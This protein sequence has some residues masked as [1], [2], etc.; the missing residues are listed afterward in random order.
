ME[1]F[2]AERDFLADSGFEDRRR[3]ALAGLDLNKIDAPI[4]DIIESLFLLPYCYTLQSCYG[5]F[6]HPGQPDRYGV[7]ALD[8]Y[9]ADTIVEYRLAYVALCIRNNEDGLALR[10]ELRGLVSIDP[11]NV[12]FGS[13]DWFRHKHINSFALQV[14]P[15]RFQYRD[16][17][18]VGIDE[19]L[20]LERTRNNVFERLST[21]VH[22]RRN[23]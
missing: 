14:E 10:A 17:A 9:T 2:A 16:T 7:E 6:V 1:T 22:E 11:Q 18:R 8:N 3:R 4:V 15:E 19:A 21:V 12:Q 13:P 23:R 5:H 20:V